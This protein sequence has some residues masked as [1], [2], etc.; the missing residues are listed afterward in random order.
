[1]VE[2]VLVAVTP[3]FLFLIGRD[4]TSNLQ[5]ADICSLL[6]AVLKIPP[7]F[8]MCHLITSLPM[9]S[10]QREKRYGVGRGRL[11]SFLSVSVGLEIIK[12]YL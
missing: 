7:I 9:P 10:C 1:M 6:Q 3:K 5:M 2:T 12:D 4:D 8:L 11:R